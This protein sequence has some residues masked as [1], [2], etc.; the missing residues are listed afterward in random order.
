MRDLQVSKRNRAIDPQGAFQ[1]LVQQIMQDHEIV[2]KENT[3][4][5]LRSMA[6]LA[7]QEASKAYLIALFE[8]TNLCA[9][10]GKCVTIMPKDLALA[11]HIQGERL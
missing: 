10:H 1:C 9:I 3:D 7:L 4:M 2:G 11:Q 8:D 5:H 6:C